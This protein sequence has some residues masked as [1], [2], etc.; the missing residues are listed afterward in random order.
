MHTHSHRRP[1]RFGRTRETAKY[2][3]YTARFAVIVPKNWSNPSLNHGHIT[4]APNL[5]TI[6]IHSPCADTQS[7]YIGILPHRVSVP[8]KL[9]QNSS[10]DP[11]DD[12]RCCLDDPA[13]PPLLFQHKR[14]CRI[15][16]TCYRAVPCFFPLIPFA[17]NPSSELVVSP[18]NAP[19]PLEQAKTRAAG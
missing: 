8:P 4:E 9:T 5:E 3:K 13:C 1:P 14:Q 10:H 12:P 19:T 6:L 2:R 15:Y 18:T 11:T 7:Y 16:K 17:H